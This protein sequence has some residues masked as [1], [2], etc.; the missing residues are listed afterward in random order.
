MLILPVGDPVA[1]GLSALFLDY[2][3]EKVKKQCWCG[4]TA[5]SCFLTR[6]GPLW[7]LTIL[8]YLSY[9]ILAPRHLLVS[10]NQKHPKLTDIPTQQGCPCASPPHF[11]S[12][13]F[14]Y[15][16]EKFW[17]QKAVSYSL[18]HFRSFT[19]SPHPWLLTLSNG[20]SISS[21]PVTHPKSSPLILHQK[22]LFQTFS[23]LSS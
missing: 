3:L 9:C 23:T 21:Y 1:S 11:T 5:K 18:L 2:L 20:S 4:L 7:T 22:C 10:N 17:N 8:F 12:L 6:A 15:F 13:F 14:S 19:V 16:I